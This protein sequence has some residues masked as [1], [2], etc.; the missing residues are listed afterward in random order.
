MLKMILLK[1]GQKLNDE[2]ESFEKVLKLQQSF[3]EKCFPHLM[4][5]DFEQLMLMNTRALIHEVIETE[6]ELNW[7]HWKTSKGINYEALEGEVV[8]Q[9][10]FIMNQINALEM[11]ANEF[12]DRV[13]VKIGVNMNRQ[14]SG[15]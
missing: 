14:A 10:I 13:L 9:F 12:L 3:Q 6:D 15:Y 2:I 8:D 7:K 4:N 1:W 11:D 5:L